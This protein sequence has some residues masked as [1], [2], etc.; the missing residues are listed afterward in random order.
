MLGPDQGNWRGGSSCG[1]VWL[2]VTRYQASAPAGPARALRAPSSLFSR[3][4]KAASS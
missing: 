3:W 1:W 2:W 4:F